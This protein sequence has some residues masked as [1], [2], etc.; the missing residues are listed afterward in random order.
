MPIIER[1]NSSHF[2]VSIQENK[3][4][5]HNISTVKHHACNQ[6]F[7]ICDFILIYFILLKNNP[8]DVQDYCSR[9]CLIGIIQ[10]KNRNILSPANN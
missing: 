9:I 3:R 1:N 5:I 10:Q 4:Q 6:T 7:S 8:Y 2:P